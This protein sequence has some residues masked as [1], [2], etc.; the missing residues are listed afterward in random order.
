MKDKMGPV[1]GIFGI[2]AMCF[3]CSILALNFSPTVGY[4]LQ[5]SFLTNE[6]LFLGCL[7]NGVYFDWD[8]NIFLVMERYLFFSTWKKEKEKRIAKIGFCTL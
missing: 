7:F 8:S 4:M 3:G 1:L 6:K 5:P 2:I